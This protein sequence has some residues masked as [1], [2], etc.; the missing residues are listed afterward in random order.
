MHD[1]VRVKPKMQWRPQEVRNAGT[2][3]EKTIGNG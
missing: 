2:P 3:A 1:A